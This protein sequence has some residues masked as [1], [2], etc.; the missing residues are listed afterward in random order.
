MPQKCISTCK[1]FSKDECNPPRCRYIDGSQRKYCR[2]SYKYKMLKPSC[3]ITRKYK[4]NEVRPAAQNKIK[5]FLN[6]SGKIL[7]MICSKSGECLAFGK[8]ID[9]IN[10][11][12]KG[13]TGFEYTVD[14][15]TPIGN[16]SANGFVKELTYKRNGYQANAILKS[17]QHKSADN[18]VY[19]YIVGVKFINRI[20]KQYPCFVQTY[21]LYFYDTL[22]HWKDMQVNRPLSK[23]VLNHLLLQN[24]IDYPKTCTHSETA[25]IL[26]QHISSAKSI[27]NFLLVNNY[28]S[29]IQYDLIYMLFIIYQA[30]SSISKTF[31]HYDLHSDNILLYEPEKGKYIKYIYHLKGGEIITF[32]SPYIPKIIDYGRSYFNNGNTNST[33]IYNKICTTPQCGI[34]GQDV[35][36]GWF[37]PISEYFISS[38][39]KNESHDLRIC[40]IIRK[41]LKNIY[42]VTKTKPTTIAFKELAHFVKKVKYGVGIKSRQGKEYGT[43]EDLTIDPTGKTVRNISDAYLQLKSVITNKKLIS[44]NTMRYIDPTKQIGILTIFE[45]GSPMTYQSS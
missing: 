37:D 21:G 36:F 15:V 29:V 25:S 40:N 26:I 12:F 20:I 11:L 6:R 19:E 43:I 18:L 2:L 9:E 13:F 44:E 28:T 1:Q 27:G 42:T 34:C 41:E 22:D 7:Q 32:L 3:K 4:K 14:P 5:E 39:K 35:G 17:S 45:N 23:A 16:I 30:L 10:T 31:T 38:S 8:K 24:Q 33:T